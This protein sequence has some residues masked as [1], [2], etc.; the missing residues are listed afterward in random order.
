[1]RIRWLP[2]IA[3]LVVAVPAISVAGVTN[4]DFE[5]GGAGWNVNLPNTEW[6]NEFPA[7]GGNPDGCAYI[8][9]PWGNSQGVGCISQTFEC[10]VPSPVDTCRISLD[11]KLVNVDA[12]PLTARVKVFLDDEL[13]FTSPPSNFID[14]TNIA[15]VA[16]CGTHSI[17]LCLEV[18]TGNN[19]WE[20]WFD[21]VQAV[22]ITG[23]PTDTSPWGLIKSLFE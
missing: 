18:D 22:C 10:G 4:G 11:Y 19:G 3:S 13:V 2:L 5:A 8:H 23:S 15:F 16:P 7:T 6:W 9:S 12:S 14:W 17:D 21:N 1:M 20:A